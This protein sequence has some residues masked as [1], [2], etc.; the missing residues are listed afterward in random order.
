MYTGDVA[1]TPSQW[2]VLQIGAEGPVFRG[3]FSVEQLGSQLKAG[4][5]SWS[6]LVYA[7]GKTLSWTRIC[8]LSEFRAFFPPM[9][10]PEIL[11]QHR[12]AYLSK[13]KGGDSLPREVELKSLPSIAELEASQPSVEEPSIGNRSAVW[14]FQMQGSEYGPVTRNQLQD[15]L[16][17]GSDGQLYVWRQ[18]LKSWV[19]VKTVQDFAQL[20]GAQHVAPSRP[21]RPVNSPPPQSNVRTQPRTALVAT[22]FLMIGS[23]WKRTVGVCADISLTGMQIV[24]DA[25][26]EF[27]LGQEYSFE[28]H[29]ASPNGDDDSL[30]FHVNAKAVWVK[31]EERRAGFAFL[32]M[33]PK[34]QEALMQCLSRKPARS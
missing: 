28:V 2:A 3:A 25:E 18:G 1:Q 24:M 30:V 4:T 16:K 31:K 6:D 9:P 11:D 26:A 19:L 27:S 33:N 32:K 21:A 22:V 17:K 12:K 7:A 14:Y 5:L 13:I 15:V 10:Q 8:D 20:L 34:D 29:P 23:K